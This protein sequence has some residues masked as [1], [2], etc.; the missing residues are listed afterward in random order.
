[1]MGN[2]LGLGRFVSLGLYYGAI[3]GGRQRGL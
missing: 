1:M 2:P 3:V